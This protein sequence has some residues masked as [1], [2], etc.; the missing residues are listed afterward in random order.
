METC[1]KE[2]SQIFPYFAHIVLSKYESGSAPYEHNDPLKVG[3]EAMIELYT[4]V[5]LNVPDWLCKH[6]F[7]ESVDLNAYHWYDILNKELFTIERKLDSFRIPVKEGPHEI[8]ERM[9]TFPAH[10]QAKKAGES[11]HIENAD[12][13]I[14]WLSKVQNLYESDKKITSCRGMRGLLKKGK[15]K[16]SFI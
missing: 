4:R 7:K 9:R 16:K 8:K 6:P 1:L 13:F 12:G 11:I 10:L 5:G 3:R 14:E 2:C 15:W